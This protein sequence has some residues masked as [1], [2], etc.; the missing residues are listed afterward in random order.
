MAKSLSGYAGTYTLDGGGRGRGIYKFT[1]NA[2]SGILE[3][4]FLAAESSN[5]SYLARSPSGKN[6]YAVNETNEYKGQK[7]GAVSAF[8][9]DE[10]SEKLTLINQ[11]FSGGLSPCHAALNAAGTH[12]LVANYSSGVLRVF[13]LDGGGGLGDAVQTIQFSGTGQNPERQEGPHAHFFMF[14][15]DEAFGFACDLGTDRIMAYAFDKNAA[16][17]LS[18]ART[19]WFSAKPGAGPRHGIFNTAGKLAYVINELDCTVDV[20]AYDAS[21]GS[22][23]KRQSLSSLPA[24]ITI[25][26]TKPQ[27]SGAAIKIHPNGKFVYASNR[28]HNS[29]AVF[30]IINDAGDLELVKVTSSGGITPRDFTLTP[31]GNFLLAA[32]QDSDNIVIFRVDNSTGLLTYEREYPLPSPVCII[33]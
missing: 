5:P 19:P 1:M 3:D 8:A 21:G 16:E 30:K 25:K 31:S 20:L 9:R 14:A 23:E 24:G 27:S 22:F 13:A 6:L 29:I 7:G 4:I 12:A 33:F 2:E 10:K 32:N 11:K 18:P 28:G 15:R 26:E 17:P